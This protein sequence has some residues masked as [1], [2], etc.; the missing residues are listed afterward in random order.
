[1]KKI[2]CLYGGPGSGKSTTAAG[3]FYHLKMLG[4]NC[5]LNREYVKDWVWE[6]REIG[7]GDQ[8]YFFAK[9][10]RK[11]RV[12]IRNGLDFIITDSPLILTHFYGLKYDWLEQNFNTSEIMLKHHH[13]YCKKHGYTTEHFIV[14]RSKEY[15]PSGRNQTRLE[16]M[17][18][19]TEIRKL[20]DSKGI[21]YTCVSGDMVM[22]ILEKLGEEK[23]RSTK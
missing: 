23:I 18:F 12:L 4:Y 17:E 5:E 1:M 21:K 13:E 8:T 11:E 16:A 7:E 6:G 3:L 20:L 2:I 9:Q 10:S 14:E 19:D 15:N 22:Q